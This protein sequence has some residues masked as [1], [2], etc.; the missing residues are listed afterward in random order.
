MDPSDRSALKATRTY[1]HSMSGE[2]FLPDQ[3]LN[4][5]E[6]E[7]DHTW[8]RQMQRRE[9]DDYSDVCDEDRTFMKLWNVLVHSNKLVCD[10]DVYRMCLD[11]VDMHKSQVRG[12]YESIVAHLMLLWD[13]HTLTADQVYH[14]QAKM[15][16]MMQKGGR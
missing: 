2:P 14:I 8:M 5:S 3:D 7:V 10:Y 11:F 9:I 15:H 4:D 1:Y 12:L 16:Q 13:N 6:I